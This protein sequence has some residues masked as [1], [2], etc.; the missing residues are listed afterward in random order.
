MDINNC[1][2]KVLSFFDSLNKELSPGFHLVDTFLDCFS[3]VSVNWKNPDAL[4]FHCNRLKDIH[5]ESLMNQDIM[6]II[7]DTSVKNNVA[8]LISHICRG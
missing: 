2:N 7:M 3:F 6:L 1:L 8:T 4:T 5:K